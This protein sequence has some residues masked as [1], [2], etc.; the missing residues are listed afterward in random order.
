MDA[1]VEGSGRTTRSVDLF[2]MPEVAL[3]LSFGKVHVFGGVA[4]S[5]FFLDGPTGNLGDTQ[6]RNGATACNGDP[7]TLACAGN[8]AGRKSERAYGPFVMVVPQI[9]AGTTF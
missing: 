2:V 5:L 4:A 8:D 6:V 7:A 9:G 1:F 3:A